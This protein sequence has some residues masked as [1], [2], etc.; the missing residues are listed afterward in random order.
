MSTPYE[1]VAVHL[2]RH[3]DITILYTY[4]I[5]LNLGGI[6]LEKLYRA[7]LKN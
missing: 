4:L 5:Y 2:L 3:N 1:F 6:D 7:T